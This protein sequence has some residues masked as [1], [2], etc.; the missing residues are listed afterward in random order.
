MPVEIEVAV[1]W[2]VQNGFMDNVPV[3]RVKECQ[4][5]LTDFLVTRKPEL[6]KTIAKQGALNDALNAELN[7]AVSQFKETWK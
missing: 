6:L 5:Q 7:A 2:A 3:E 4:T 1:L